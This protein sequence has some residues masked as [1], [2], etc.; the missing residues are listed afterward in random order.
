MDKEIMSV[1][2]GVGG[3]MQGVNSHRAI[4]F[5]KHTLFCPKEN[6]KS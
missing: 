3:A 6:G 1:C 5:L 4:C 2:K